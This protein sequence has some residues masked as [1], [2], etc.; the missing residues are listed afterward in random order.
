MLEL[1]TSVK[2]ESINIFVKESGFS[3]D[4]V[5]KEIDNIEWISDIN[6]QDIIT[7]QNKLV[8]LQDLGQISSGFEIKDFLWI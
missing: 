8:F 3:K 1:T 5:S 2:E 6:E 4:V 7:L